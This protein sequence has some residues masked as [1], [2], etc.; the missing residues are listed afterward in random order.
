MVMRSDGEEHMLEL[1]EESTLMDTNVGLEPAFVSNI[2]L[3]PGEPGDPDPF[4]DAEQ[5]QMERLRNSLSEEW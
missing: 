2:W 1:I 5:T 4:E 3:D